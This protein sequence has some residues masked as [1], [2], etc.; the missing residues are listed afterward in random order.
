MSNTTTNSVKDAA[1]NA[2]LREL[3]HDLS[4]LKDDAATTLQDAAILAKNLKSEG[5][6]IARDGVKNLA[7]VGRNEFEKLEDR[8]REKPGQS[9][10]LA[11]CAG[12]VFSYIL[13]SRR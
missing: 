12:L 5:G 2:G 1:N 8:V 13:G 11:F 7:A 10:A 4:V 3:R 6:A 9:V